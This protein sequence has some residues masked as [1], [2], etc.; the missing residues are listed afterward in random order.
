MGERGREGE[1]AA[2]F[3]QK[4]YFPNAQIS[5]STPN[6]ICL[7]KMLSVFPSDQQQQSHTHN[8]L[9]TQRSYW[10]KFKSGCSV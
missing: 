2:T 5:P 8:F 1:V 10:F 3:D 7:K 6:L 4:R 9:K